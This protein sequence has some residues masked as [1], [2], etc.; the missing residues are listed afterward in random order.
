MVMISEQGAARVINVTMMTLLCA[1]VFAFAVWMLVHDLS[2][3]RGVFDR[4]EG[5]E[6][7]AVA[8]LGSS[9]SL[10]VLMVSFAWSGVRRWLRR[11]RVERAA[12]PLAHEEAP[13]S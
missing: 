9:A 6:R 1:V 13:N 8:R 2:V 3:A 12:T 7:G 10:I 4:L 5:E 11:R